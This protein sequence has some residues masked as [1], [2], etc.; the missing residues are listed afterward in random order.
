ML[1]DAIAASGPVPARMS[2]RTSVGSFVAITCEMNPPRE[3]P[4]RSTCSRPSARV[5]AIASSAMAETVVGVRPLLP[6][7]PRLSKVITRRSDAIPS[8]TRGSQSS[9]TAVK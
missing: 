8:M 9:R 3:N 1:A 2:L 6:P 4:I 7:M 5:K